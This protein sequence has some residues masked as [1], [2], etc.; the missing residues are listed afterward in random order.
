MTTMSTSAL[1]N[2]LKVLFLGFSNSSAIKGKLLI[3]RGFNRSS[4]WLELRPGSGLRQ[5]AFGEECG[6]KPYHENREQLIARQSA[7]PF[8]CVTNEFG[9]ESES[10]IKDQVK[11]E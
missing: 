1:R 2:C 6:P 7:E 5:R 9:S 11:S 8:R 4:R 3:Q 10:P